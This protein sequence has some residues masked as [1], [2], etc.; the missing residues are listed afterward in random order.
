MRGLAQSKYGEEASYT[1]EVQFFFSTCDLNGAT[2]WT[3]SAEGSL[4][5]ECSLHK[6]MQ[7][8]YLCEACDLQVCVMFTLLSD[9][10]TVVAENNFLIRA[11][12]EC[13]NCISK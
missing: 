9:K 6:R 3:A 12:Q 5:K 8:L 2:D 7:E 1:C 11:W 13:D 4:G 10:L